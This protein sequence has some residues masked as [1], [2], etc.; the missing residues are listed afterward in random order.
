[1]FATDLRI[2]NLP[3]APLLTNEQVAARL[4]NPPPELAVDLPAIQLGVESEIDGPFGMF[5]RCFRTYDLSVIYY[6]IVDEGGVLDNL[7]ELPGGPEA[8]NITVR[9]LDNTSYTLTV[10]K[11]GKIPF[12][13][14]VNK[15]DL[16]KVKLPL[17][18]NYETGTMDQRAVSAALDL[19]AQRWIARDGRSRVSLRRIRTTVGD[20]SF[21]T[22]WERWR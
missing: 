5:A 7:F 20:A 22:G 17:V 8:T 21:L 1:M 15:E 14:F 10:N 3:S 2:V 6:S 19:L 18:F 16:Y 9:D 12:A 13:S 11:R 4:G